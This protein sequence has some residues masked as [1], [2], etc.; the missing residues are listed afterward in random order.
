MLAAQGRAG[1]HL[2][3]TGAC[4]EAAVLHLARKS[5]TALLAFGLRHCEG[6]EGQSSCRKGSSDVLGGYPLFQACLF[7]LTLFGWETGCGVCFLLQSLPAGFRL[8]Q[9]SERPAP[10]GLRPPSHQLASGEPCTSIAAQF[11][12]YFLSIFF[13]CCFGVVFFLFGSPPPRFFSFF[14]FWSGWVF[15]RSVVFFFFP[16]DLE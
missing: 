5:H 12:F 13:P 4:E 14:F 6:T 10:L 1:V 7:L 16:T 8:P 3:A 15:F 11:E 9:R 2:F